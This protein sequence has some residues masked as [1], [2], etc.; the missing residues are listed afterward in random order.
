MFSS[1][2]SLWFSRRVL[3]PPPPPPPPHPS[4]RKPNKWLFTC[5]SLHCLERRSKDSSSNKTSLDHAPAD[6][7]LNACNH[8]SS[9]GITKT[10]TKNDL[11]HIKATPTLSQG[12]SLLFKI[13]GV[14][15]PTAG[16]VHFEQ[17]RPMYRSTYRPTLDWCV[18]RHIVRNSIDIT[19]E[20]YRSTYR[21]T[22]QPRYRQSDD[23]YIGRLSAD[24]SP[25][26]IKRPTLRRYV[27]HWLS[28]EY[29]S[30]VL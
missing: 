10:V 19:T 16:H 24:I 12:A 22:C 14:M 28:A 9:L 13:A 8:N 27:D 30:T 5:V 4:Q 1:D 23:R 25:S 18:G 2:S 3:A 11:C 6:Y 20:M 17:P 15:T 26:P 29:R 21:S 7:L